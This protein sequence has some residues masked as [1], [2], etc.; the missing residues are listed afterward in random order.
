MLYN[1][2]ILEF[3]GDDVARAAPVRMQR[4]WR[5]S[6]LN[7][8]NKSHKNSEKQLKYLTKM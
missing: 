4:I 3:N 1:K 5:G 2:S 7:E 8:N 6:K